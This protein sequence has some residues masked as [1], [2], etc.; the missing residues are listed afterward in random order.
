MAHYNVNSSVQTLIQH[1]WVISSGQFS[2]DVSQT[3]RTILTAEIS[4]LYQWANVRSR[5]ARSRNRPL[6]T[7]DFNLFYTLRFGFRPS[8]IAFLAMH[9]WKETS[10]VDWP[11]GLPREQQRHYELAEIRKWL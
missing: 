7:A 4:E 6:C 2:D 9:A 5:K 10:T 11:V 3:L 8:K 1:L